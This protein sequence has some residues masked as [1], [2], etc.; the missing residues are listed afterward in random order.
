MDSIE[1]QLEECQAKQSS[2]IQGPEAAIHKG[3]GLGLAIK[4]PHKAIS[5]DN[6]P[7]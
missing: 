6:N 4:W 1:K 5:Q 3:A 7:G 2:T